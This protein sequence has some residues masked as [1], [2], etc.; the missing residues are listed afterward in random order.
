ME[1]ELVQLRIAAELS[2]NVGTSQGS[3]LAKLFGFD[4]IEPTEAEHI[5]KV[6]YKGGN[7]IARTLP[8]ESSEAA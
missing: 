7:C 5:Y 8:F 2:T 1:E 4:Y 3:D 6:S